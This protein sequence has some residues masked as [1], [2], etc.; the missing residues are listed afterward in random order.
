MVCS[1]LVQLVPEAIQFAIQSGEF[2]LSKQRM[3]L[4]SLNK[5]PQKRHKALISGDKTAAA[6]SRH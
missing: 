6:H 1:K 5:F 3:T 4:A 2:A